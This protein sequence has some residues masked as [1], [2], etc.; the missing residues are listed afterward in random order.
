MLL[1][2]FEPPRPC[3]GH[4]PPLLS[5]PLTHPFTPKDTFSPQRCQ[6]LLPHHWCPCASDPPSPYQLPKPSPAMAR[7]SLRCTQ[8]GDMSHSC[9][10]TGNISTSPPTH[11]DLR[12]TETP[13]SRT[14]ASLSH[15]HTIPPSRQHPLQS[16]SPSDAHEVALQKHHGPGNTTGATMNIPSKLSLV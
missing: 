1:A 6:T 15:A 13:L 16:C 12:I 9:S 7:E 11:T 14:S 10:H 2:G 5:C 3:P 4:H 8:T